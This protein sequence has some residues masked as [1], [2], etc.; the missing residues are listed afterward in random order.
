MLS[1]YADSK[2]VSLMLENN[3]VTKPVFAKF[4]ESPLLFSSPNCMDELG[5]IFLK[6]VGV[7]LD[8]GHLKVSANTLNFCPSDFV[9]SLPA[10]ILGYH[11]SDNNGLEDSN[12]P[13][14]EDCWFF[15]Y[16][17]SSVDYCTVEV[18]S[19][20]KAAVLSSYNS[21]KKFFQS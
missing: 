20:N 17:N 13:F 4:G 3:V 7:L 18:S 6:D 2:Q 16:L 9:S 5:E 10:E 12:Q 11:L 14:C 21:S 1:D 8:F 19:E 15:K